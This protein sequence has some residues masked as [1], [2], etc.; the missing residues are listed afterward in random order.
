MRLAGGSAGGD[1]H[2]A[3]NES[4]EAYHPFS[5]LI[6][7]LSGG[8]SAKKKI[9][10]NHQHCHFTLSLLIPPVTLGPLKKA[11]KGT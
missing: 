9:F 8:S 10:F 4:P 5:A 1:E 2:C 11:R 3:R 6:V 7:G